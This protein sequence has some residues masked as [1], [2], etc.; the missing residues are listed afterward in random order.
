M[1]G[2]GEHMA[3][4]H[5]VN[6]VER[7]RQA[8]ELRKAGADYRA[9]AEKLGY[10][11]PSGAHNAVKNALKTIIKEPAEAVRDLELARLDAMLLAIWPKVR[12]GNEYAIDRALKI[13]DR[14][15]AYLGIDAPKESKSTVVHEL[16]AVAKRI[17]ADLG[18]DAAD[19]IAEAERIVA[20]AGAAD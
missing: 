2:R 17:A 18:L 20:S 13:M 16:D 6:A 7:Q 14:R 1:A 5:R 4:E 19:V 8:L 3:S 9:I 10:K 15:S 12:Q 11:S